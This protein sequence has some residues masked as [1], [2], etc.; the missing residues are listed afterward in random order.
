VC[1]LVG[2]DVGILGGTGPA[3]KALAA[4]LASV[5]LDVRIGSRQA[6]RAEAAAAQLR[7]K[8]EG[9][10]LPLAGAGNEE[11]CASDLVVL[12]TP[13]D[14]AAPLARA[15]APA[16]EGRVVICM[17]NALGKVGEELVALFPPSGSIT[18]AVQQAAPSAFVAG[19]FHHLP[20]RVLADLDADLE[21]DVLVCS[22]HAEATSA[23]VALAD[24]IPGCRGVD[25]GSLSAAAA[26][27]AFTAVLVGINVKH[28]AHASVKL[29]GFQPAGPAGA[30]R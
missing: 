18:L 9:R 3:G 24:R 21:A 15:L 1:K 28:R 25:A 26:I 6:E 11:A 4:R 23:A 30:P 17:V 22:D 27:E 5:G 13:W 29:T 16:L 20:A 10:R 7:Q 19:A 2:M 8:W 12:A 14:G